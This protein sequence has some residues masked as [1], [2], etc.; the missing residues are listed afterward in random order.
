MGRRRQALAIDDWSCPESRLPL[1]LFE[2][3]G[4][5]SNAF[6][7]ELLLIRRASCA[8][9]F[10]PPFAWALRWAIDRRGFGAY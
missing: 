5:G 10:P 7:Q 8:E 2:V 3:E 1:P 9:C 4:V 6:D